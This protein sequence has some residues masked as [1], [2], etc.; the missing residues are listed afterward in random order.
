[1]TPAPTTQ[2]RSVGESTVAAAVASD[3]AVVA[4]RFLRFSRSRVGDFAARLPEWRE[5]AGESGRGREGAV[6]EWPAESVLGGSRAD[7]GMSR[8][9][10][11]SARCGGARVGVLLTSCVSRFGRPRAAAAQES[12]VDRLARSAASWSRGTVW[13]GCS[14]VYGV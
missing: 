4:R 13:L 10:P 9:E 7:S 1:M 8:N 11:G 3:G 6:G 14:N 12:R 2:V 5:E